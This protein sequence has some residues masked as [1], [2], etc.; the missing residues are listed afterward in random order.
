MHDYPD[1][2]SIES[3]NDD[4]VL[5]TVFLAE[6]ERVIGTFDEFSGP[7]RFEWLLPVSG[8]GDVLDV[9]RDAPKGLGLAGL[10]QR[11]RE[12]FGTLSGL[13]VIADDDADP[14]L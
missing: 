11:L 10:E 9:L 7:Q 5:H 14:V 13:R 4:P 8:I 1:G 3:G 12:R 6:L 2:D